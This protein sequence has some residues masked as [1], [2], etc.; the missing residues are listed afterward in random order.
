M[1][2]L[3]DMTGAAGA[4]R[5]AIIASFSLVTAIAGVFTMP[6]LD[7]DEARF[8]QASAQMIETGDYVTIRFQEEERN[9]KPA[10]I[11]W[12][13]AASVETFSSVNAREIWAYRLPSVAGAVMAALFTYLAGAR[14]FGPA[15]GFIAA[16]LLASAP[17][18]AGEA[19][20]A[21]TDAML[22]A[23]VAGAQAAFIA[24]FAGAID[25]RRA[26]LA[27][28][29]GF[30]VAVGAG[31][32]I[33]GP[34]VLMV[35]GLTAVSMFFFRPKGDW[36]AALRPVTGVIVLT[37]MIS[38][39]AFL[40]HSA[41]NGRFF[42]EAIGGDM[43]GKLADA[44]ESHGGPPGYYAV[45][46]FALFWPASALILPG[47]RAT[48][49]AR[50]DWRNWF[51][52]SWVAP[53]WII[54]ELTATKLPHYVLP[55]YPAIA[56]IA[57]NAAVTGAAG[58]SPRL[59]RAGAAIYMMAGVAIAAV[60][61]AL[62]VIY[63]ESGLRL[64]GFTAAAAIA[65]ASLACGLLFFAG[66][67]VEGAIMA[68]L[69]SSALA[70]TLL[71]G[72][73]PHLDRLALSPRVS[74]AIDAAGLHPLRDGAKPAILSGYY[75]PSAIFLLGTRTI[76][77]DGAS[78]AERFANADCAAVIE[79][80]EEPAFKNRL[81]ALGVSAEKFAEVAGVNYSNGKPTML[82]LYRHA[83][84]AAISGD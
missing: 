22:L 68:T 48:V 13:Q 69:I 2:L 26:R 7:R 42:I 5:L 32:L 61:A 17:A 21:K 57:A 75:E 81:N 4:A 39:W 34:I 84:T 14:L 3:S 43:L 64:Y 60:I 80:L 55:L 11:H 46:L 16:L 29:L 54:F 59:R 72:V 37:L 52:L 73:L 35:V 18:V 53:S 56:L 44:K 38:P 83:P 79:A 77:G 8:A 49:A 78:A 66:R 23:C 6:P 82:R 63:L 1:N 74:A 25:G 33:K 50:S 28:A 76:L 24:L 36:V 20:I 19:T 51:A 10:G 41:T 62:P 40:I 47:L 30:W 65:G 9:K 27:L 67:A 58:A 45:L 71:A 70:W 12:L 31:V 15:A